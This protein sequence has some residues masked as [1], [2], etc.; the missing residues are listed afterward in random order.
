[1]INLDLPISLTYNDVSISL[2]GVGINR[3]LLDIKSE[4]IERCE[5]ALN[6]GDIKMTLMS[7]LY[8]ELDLIDLH[9]GNLYFSIIKVLESHFA[10]VKK[11]KL[12]VSCDIPE[13]EYYSESKVNSV[14]YSIH[15]SYF[16]KIT[17]QFDITIRYGGL[18]LHL[19]LVIHNRACSV[20]MGRGHYSIKKGV[21]LN[22]K[23]I[24]L[25]FVGY[26]YQTSST[27]SCSILSFTSM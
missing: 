11:S 24:S 4:F 17:E 2:Q 18:I 19:Y 5:D 1:M 3:I 14:K 9:G 15:N 10:T 7:S 13:F 20:L 21:K 22:P 8:S 12:N 25:Y 26:E 16:R 23:H 6:H 27:A